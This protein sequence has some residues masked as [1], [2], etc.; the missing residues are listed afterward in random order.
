MLSWWK[1][2]RKLLHKQRYYCTCNVHGLCQK[3]ADKT[4][5]K[6]QHHE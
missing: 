2:L 5:K 4:K 1:E 3:F 6:V